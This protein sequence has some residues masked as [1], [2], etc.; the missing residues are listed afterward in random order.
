MKIMR[1]DRY[2]KG[3]KDAQMQMMQYASWNETERRVEKEH[4]QGFVPD[5]S[6]CNV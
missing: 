6:Q 4:L 2:E 5:E 1:R 3:R